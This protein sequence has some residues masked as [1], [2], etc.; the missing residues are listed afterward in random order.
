MQIQQKETYQHN[1]YPNERG[2]FGRFGGKFVPESLMM[3]LTELEGAYQQACSDSVF[4]AEL[5]MQLASFVGRPTTLHYV[6]R[7][8]QMVASGVKVYLNGDR[9]KVNS[10]KAYMEMYTKA[11]ER[12]QVQVED[13]DDDGQK[14]DDRADLDEGQDQYRE[15]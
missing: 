7:F 3:A 2:R 14:N 15:G 4:Q 9:V 13:E 6:P 12:E 5:H 11:I 10:F 1:L 8:S